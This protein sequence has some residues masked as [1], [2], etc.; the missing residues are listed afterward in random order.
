MINPKNPKL[1]IAI[2]VLVA[3]GAGVAYA[4]FASNTVSLTGNQLTTGSANVKLCDVSG[5]NA[6]LESITPGF[7]LAG[8]VPGEERDLMGTREIYLGND[9][10][11][12]ATSF[13][14]ARCGAYLATA[15]LSN[16]PVSTVPTVQFNAETCADPLPSNVKLRFNIN[17]I[18]TDAKTLT[19]WSSNTTKYGD[20]ILPGKVAAVKAFAQLS[21]TAT[22][23]N[24]RCDFTVN[25]TGKQPTA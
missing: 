5:G 22:V 21:T 9:N 23:Q 24:G 1:L 3:A 8:M 13:A 16:T 17:G 4:A 6:W 14:D 19:A 7:D 25:F 18:D 10:S 2:G 15:G 11:Q 12:L 20:A